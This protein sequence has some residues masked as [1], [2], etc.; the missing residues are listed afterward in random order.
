MF[1]GLNSIYCMS[2]NTTFCKICNK[3]LSWRGLGR[4]LTDKH[5][6]PKHLASKQYF[7]TYL[8]QSE[9]VCKIPGCINTTNFRSVTEGYFDY[10]T[11]CTEQ[12]AFK[13]GVV[14]SLEH[15]EKTRQSVL[16]SEYHKSIKGKPLSAAKK[17]AIANKLQ[18]AFT[19][20]WFVS[21]HGEEG[22]ALYRQRCNRIAKTSHFREYNKKNKNNYSKVSQELFWLLYK[23]KL[24]Q[25]Q[26]YFA[27]LNHEYSCGNTHVNFDFVIKNRRKVIEF[28]GDLFHGNPELFSEVDTPNPYTKLTAKE[29]WELDAAKHYKA[30]EKGYDVLVVWET[31]Y[32]QDKQAIVKRCEDFIN[33]TI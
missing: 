11:T 6:Y 13:K 5:G 31:E 20:D 10:C 3:G 2:K 15:R 18:G 32:K 9:P 8:K 14:V 29:I 17:E 26:V 1:D 4:H 25:E 23:G 30:M 12:K 21:K 22:K 16:N 7:D 27:E 33:G 24:E 19:L 28:N